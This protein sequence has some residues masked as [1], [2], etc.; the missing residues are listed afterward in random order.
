MKVSRAWAPINRVGVELEGGWSYIPVG[1]VPDG[2]VNDFGCEFSGELPSPAF[3][4]W[5]SLQRWIQD[6]YPDFVDNSCGLHVHI[7]LKNQGN[8]PRLMDDAFTNWAQR[9]LG[10][11]WQKTRGLSL[12]EHSR[13]RHRLAGGNTY[14]QT[15]VR[16]LEQRSLLRKTSIRY[17]HWNF[18][19]ALHGT[20]ECRILP[21][22]ATPDTALLGIASVIRCVNAWLYGGAQRVRGNPLS[23]NEAEVS[24]EVPTRLDESYTWIEPAAHSSRSSLFGLEVHDVPNFLG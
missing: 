24:N 9:Y 3:P 7:S 10:H 2:S 8:Y 19:Y 14:A 22:F 13:L 18:C 5:G 11:F 21:M 1:S 16:S 17:T 23:Y 12:T 15:E 4:Y 6:H 20:V